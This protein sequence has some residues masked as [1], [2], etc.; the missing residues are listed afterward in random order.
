M[1]LK[2]PVNPKKPV[3]MLDNGSFLTC[4]IIN[5]ILQNLLV[6]VIGSK[7]KDISAHSFR[8]ALPSLLASH[9]DIANTEDIRCW[10]RWSSSGSHGLYTRLKRNQKRL[11]YNKII[12]AL[13]RNYSEK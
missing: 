13:N 2:S 5:G 10:G 8:G 12:S 9:P 1:E 4:K 6:P 7:A 11:I 3:F